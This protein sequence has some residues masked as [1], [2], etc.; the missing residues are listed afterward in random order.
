MHGGRVT[1]A[2]ESAVALHLGLSMTGTLQ[3]SG[4]LLQ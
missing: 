2:L 1:I 3:S 4:K